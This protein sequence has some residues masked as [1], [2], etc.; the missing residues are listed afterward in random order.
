MQ[1]IKAVADFMGIN[2]KTPEEEKEECFPTLSFKERLLGFA[3]CS[4]LGFF[5]E[6]ISM[7]SLIG[8]FVGNPY[9]FGILFTLG[10][11]LSVLG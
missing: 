4:V 10:N 1:K 11:I 2:Q 3:V 5:I 6:L 8:L 9:K 7:G